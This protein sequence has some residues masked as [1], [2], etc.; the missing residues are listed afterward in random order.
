MSIFR[1]V[2]T[3]TI[4]GANETRGR[5]WASAQCASAQC[6]NVHTTVLGAYADPIHPN[7]MKSSAFAH[8]KPPSNLCACINP[9]SAI[10]SAGVSSPIIGSP[11]S[12]HHH[13][14]VWLSLFSFPSDPPECTQS[15]LQRPALHEVSGEKLYFR[16][17]GMLVVS[18][19]GTVVGLSSSLRGGIAADAGEQEKLARHV[20][21]D[22]SA[23]AAG[24]DDGRP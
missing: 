12:A 3:D 9:A 7:P 14:H 20:D 16:S 17:S 6:V 10:G 21:V 18:L 5:C 1:Q 19:I 11:Y 22:S 2:S 23:A 4:Q 15:S 24:A 13:T 8:S